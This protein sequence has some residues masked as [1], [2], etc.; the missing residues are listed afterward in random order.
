MSMELEGIIDMVL[1]H[2]I[3]ILSSRFSLVYKTILFVLIISLIFT[4]FAV[5]ALFPTLAPLYYEIKEVQIFEHIGEALS[6]IFSGDQDA[7]T[8]KFV[9]VKSDYEEV[10]NIL[11]TKI[12]VLWQAVVW[13][14]V[15]VLL[16]KFFLS[17]IYLTISDVSNH[18]MS[19]N[20][21][22]GFTSNYISNLK[23]SFAYASINTIIT[24]PYYVIC[25]LIIWGVMAFLSMWSLFIAMIALLLMF[26]VF[27]SLKKTY[28]TCWLPSIIVENKGVIKSLKQNFS[29]SYKMANSNMGLFVFYYFVM[30]SITL[31][32]GITTLGIGFFISMAIC[33]VLSNIMDM[34]IYY[35]HMGLR[36]YSDA[37][38]IVKPNTAITDKK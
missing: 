24:I 37:D 29:M 26:I 1:K 31:I 35:R 7:Q 19:S 23:K 32:F 2:S 20:S 27:M 38:T 6:S 30:A 3:N 15:L 21:R 18:F 5:S 17:T 11:G 16:F 8:E 10:I 25:G 4:A 28:L 34:V 14:I 12:N 36:Y 33:V 13:I 9:L 22:F